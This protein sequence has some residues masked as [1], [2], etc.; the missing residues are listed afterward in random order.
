MNGNEKKNTMTSE[1]KDLLIRIITKSSDILRR[2]FPLL[3]QRIVPVADFFIKKSR[4]SSPLLFF[5]CKK[6]Q[7]LKSFK[8]CQFLITLQFGNYLS[9]TGFQ[10]ISPA[11]VPYRTYA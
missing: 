6:S 3:E 4:G 8:H 5:S 9:S 10:L 11:F 2:L 7:S 1:E